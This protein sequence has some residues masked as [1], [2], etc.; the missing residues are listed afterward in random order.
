M[1]KKNHRESLRCL[2][3]WRAQHPRTDAD[4]DRFCGQGGSTI[5]ITVEENFQPTMGELPRVQKMGCKSLVDI[6]WG[7]GW[8]NS[9]SCRPLV[10]FPETKRYIA[11]EAMDDWK[12][13]R[14]PFGVNGL[15]SGDM[16]VSGRVYHINYR[17]VNTGRW[18]IICRKYLK[19]IFQLLFRSADFWSL[20]NHCVLDGI[21]ASNVSGHTL[22]ETL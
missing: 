4:L 14:F 12:T 2:Q 8:K 13:I 3:A 15:F 10:T 1:Q 7:G 11:P 9:G 5:S 22:R 6:T 19:W 21:I 17:F 16:L 20:R 18:W